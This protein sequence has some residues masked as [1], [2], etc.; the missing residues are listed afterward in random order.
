MKLID[1]LLGLKDYKVQLTKLSASGNDFII[2]HTFIKK[3]RSQLAK[4][5]CDRFEGIGADGLIV[6][7]PHDSYDFEWE[8]YNSD[9]SVASMCG[10]GS[11]AAA[12]YAFLNNLSPKKMKFLTLAGV[13]E[14]EVF[15][16]EVESMLTP[17]K[18]LSSEFEELGF[19]WSFYD[20]GVPHLVSFVDDL[21]KFDLNICTT[22]RQKYDANVN[23]AKIEDEKLFVRT[24]ERGVEGETKACG[25][26]MASCFLD[27]V[28]KQQIDKIDVFPKSSEKLSLSFKNERLFLRG[29][30]RKIFDT[31]YYG[32]DI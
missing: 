26:G 23:F 21:S 2:F 4:K 7:V 5:L 30:V 24:F 32:G 9:G 22:M 14:A 6:L 17:F 3:D 25:T 28:L 1:V 27:M 15:E 11:R 31:I 20:T 19:K 10:N 8:F 16:N 29:E 13:I 12:Y 18:I